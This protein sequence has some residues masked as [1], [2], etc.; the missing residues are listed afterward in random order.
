MTNGDIKHYV[1]KIG[2]NMVIVH[3]D[4]FGGKV[5]RTLLLGFFLPAL[6]SRHYP[7]EPGG[8]SEEFAI[9]WWI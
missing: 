1:F 2:S 4:A 7:S 3:G 9:C 6:E 5:R 8:C